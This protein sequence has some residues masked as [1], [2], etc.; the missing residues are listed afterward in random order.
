MQIS[1]WD[2]AI[3]KVSENRDVS[4]NSIKFN[5]VWYNAPEVDNY[6]EYYT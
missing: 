1:D 5:K 6:S 2:N 3:K 4:I